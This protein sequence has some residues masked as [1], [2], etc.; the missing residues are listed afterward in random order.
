M[1][2]REIII[3][4]CG[5]HSRSVADVLLSDRPDVRLIFID[6]AAQPEETLYGF[7]VLC[8]CSS[9]DQFYFFAIGDNEKRQKK[10][11]EIGADHL[12]TILSSK[13]YIGRDVTLDKGVFAGNFVHIGPEVHIGT[14]TILNNACIVEHEVHIGC[15][16]HIG[17]RAVISGRSTIDDRVF[18]GVGATIKDNITVC[19]DV[20]IGAGAVIV[21]DITEPGTYVGCPGKRLEHSQALKFRN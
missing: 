3:F 10:Y 13:A 18:V 9:K 5:G 4:G 15:H 2:N 1:F 21:K 7:P 20:T 19:S 12:L 6:D 14:N 16:C 8:H 17:P 11:L